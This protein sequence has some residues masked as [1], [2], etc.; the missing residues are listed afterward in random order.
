MKK[1]SSQNETPINGNPRGV[2]LKNVPLDV[3][4]IF[5]PKDKLNK[6][7]LEIYENNEQ[8][9]PLLWV[10]LTSKEALEI[11]RNL[12]DFANGSDELNRSSKKT[13]RETSQK[14]NQCPAR[15]I[16]PGG[17]RCQLE[18]GHPGKHAHGSYEW[19]NDGLPSQSGGQQG[20]EN[21]KEKET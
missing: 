17:L 13:Q 6:V 16:R 11:G 12:I 19:G 15:R 3:V 4:L 2:T 7:A 14:L 1:A 9:K 10:T 8:R 20:G 21:E 18:S 5:D